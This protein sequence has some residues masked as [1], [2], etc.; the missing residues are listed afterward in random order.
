MKVFKFIQVAVSN[1]K[2][3][4]QFSLSLAARPL[5]AYWATHYATGFC[6]HGAAMTTLMEKYIDENVA[7]T[8]Q[9][10]SQRTKRL[11]VIGN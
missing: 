5:P 4:R 9:L 10:Y 8:N 11:K 1:F 2:I 6:G 7:R 3:E